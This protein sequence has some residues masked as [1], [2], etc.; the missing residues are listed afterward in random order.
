MIQKACSLPVDAITL[1]LEDA[2]P[3]AEKEAARKLV[4]DNLSLLVSEGSD[5]YVRVNSL[6]TGLTT[7][8]L[9]A[10]LYQGLT[11]IMLPK[12]ESKENIHELER[13][14]EA[15]EEDRKLQ[16]RSIKLIP[17]LESALGVLNAYEIAK[18]SERVVALSFGAVDFVADV[19]ASITEDRTELLYARSRI[20][21]AARAAGI[22]AIDAVFTDFKDDEGLVKD[23]QSGRRLGFQGKLI[24]H[25]NQIEAVNQIFSPSEREIEYARK[26]VEAFRE[27]EAKGLGATSLEGK[28]IDIAN[29]RWAENILSLA[30]AISKRRERHSSKNL[31][32]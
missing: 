18:A 11:G 14:I 20:V 4:R 28:M 30:E 9:E 24:I 26:I 19:G 32:Q 16:P 10:V 15:L 8:D 6:K 25:P 13:L 1:D 23:A 12:C 5:V 21:L 31:N 7:K 27:A 17:Q 22:Q 29:Y 2:V 3:I